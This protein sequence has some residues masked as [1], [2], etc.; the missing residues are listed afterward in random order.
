MNEPVNITYRYINTDAKKD[1]L[2]SVSKCSK[3]F[4]RKWH[5]ID[6]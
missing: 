1:R 4:Y 2:D 5:D 6:K 3:A